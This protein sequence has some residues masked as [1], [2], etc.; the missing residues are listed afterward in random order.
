MAAFFDA[1]AAGYDN[2]MRVNVVGYAA[3]YDAVAAAIPSTDAPIEVLDLGIGTGLELDGLFERA[4][5]ARVTGIDVSSA[6]LD[7]LRTKHARRLDQLILRN[8]SFLDA[9]LG[10]GRY[11]AAVSVMALHHWRPPTKRDLYRRILSALRADGRFIDAD[12]V[13]VAEESE[14][15]LAEHAA[16]LRTGN[17]EPDGMRHIDIPLTVDVE[18]RLLLDAG[19][20]SVDTTYHTASAAVLVALR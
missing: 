18:Q 9:D 11:A 6:M 4:P 15:M 12:Y 20:S 14:S 5:N 8:E 17:V 1:R 16:R 2:H 7:Q 10:E 13:V 19:F 3:F